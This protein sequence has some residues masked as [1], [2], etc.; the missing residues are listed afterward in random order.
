MLVEYYDVD[1]TFAHELCFPFDNEGI[2]YVKV[3]GNEVVLGESW[4][5]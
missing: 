3:I 5:F 4:S 2:T 1:F